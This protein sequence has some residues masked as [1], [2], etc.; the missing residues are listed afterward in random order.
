MIQVRTIR[1]HINRH[2][3]QPVK[4]FGRVYEVSE[5]EAA[6]LAQSGLV[7]I[8]KSDADDQD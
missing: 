2:G 1:K 6:N 4:N 8:V 5:T 7:E 3:P